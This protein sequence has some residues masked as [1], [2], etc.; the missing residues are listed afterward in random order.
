MMRIIVGIF[1]HH[2]RHHRASAAAT[3]GGT[4]RVVAA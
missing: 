3:S 1:A 2:R 4:G